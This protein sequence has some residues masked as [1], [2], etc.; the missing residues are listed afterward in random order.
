MSIR[1]QTRAPS[2]D[3]DRMDV[4]PGSTSGPLFGRRARTAREWDSPARGD[5]RRAGSGGSPGRG[6]R[7]E[8]AGAR[9]RVRRDRRRRARPYPRRRNCGRWAQDTLPT[10]DTVFRIASMTKSFTAATV[11]LL[12][13]EGHL[14]LDDPAADHVPELQ[15]QRPL[16]S[17]DAPRDHRAAPPVDVGGLPGRRPVGRSPAG[18]GPRV[19]SPR[20]SRRASSF[21]WMPGTELR[22]LEPRTT[23][24]SGA[25][26]RTSRVHEYRDVVRVA[27]ARAHGHG[28]DRLRRGRGP[29]RA[30]RGRIRP[31][32]RRVPRGTVR[33][34]RGASPSMGGLF[35]TVH[36]LA[37]WVD[38]LR[39]T[40]SPTSAEADDHP[41]SRA[42]RLEM[43]QVHRSIAPELT[44]TSV[45]ATDRPRS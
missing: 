10:A 25:S 16:A 41:L 30:T 28:L 1:T 34:L 36:D 35:S 44:W 12:R 8:G 9:R 15:G 29:R 18:S 21:A 17:G 45:A 40:P 43:Q 11:L 31:A 33:R 22:V 32:R 13:D 3:L 14:R 26:S 6:V 23:P 5:R 42:S 19:G 24:S 37:R 7:R 38:G 27:S 2:A 20:S 4:P 39:A